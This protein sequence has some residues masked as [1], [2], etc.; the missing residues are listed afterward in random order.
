M[1]KNLVYEILSDKMYMFPEG[2]MQIREQYVK[3]AK[4][5]K[6]GD[7]IVHRAR[8]ITYVDT[9]RKKPELVSLLTNDMEMDPP[10]IIDIYRKRW[11]I[12]LLFK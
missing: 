5:L 1:K 12:E 3:F 9:K 2:L 8:I 6:G 7:N 4:P 10:E 11:G